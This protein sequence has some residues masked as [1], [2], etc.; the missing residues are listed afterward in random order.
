MVQ[1]HI[2][3]AI[4]QATHNVML[5]MVEEDLQSNVKMLVEVNGEFVYK[6]RILENV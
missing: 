5:K 3:K 6:S 4:T 1:I 2:D